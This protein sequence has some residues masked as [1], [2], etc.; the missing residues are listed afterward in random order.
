MTNHTR[1]QHHSNRAHHHRNHRGYTEPISLALI[2]HDRPSNCSSSIFYSYL[3]A[4]ISSFLVVLGIYLTLTRFEAHFLYISLVGLLI[5]ATS[6]CI[7]CLSNI[8]KSRLARRKQTDDFFLEN[9]QPIRH[10]NHRQQIRT[11]THILSN[12]TLTNQSPSAITNDNNTSRTIS[13][14]TAQ[15]NGIRD[16]TSVGVLTEHMVSNGHANSIELSRPDHDS[17]APQQARHLQFDHADLNQALLSNQQATNSLQQLPKNQNCYDLPNLSDVTQTIINTSQHDNNGN[18]DEAMTSAEP[19]YAYPSDPRVPI[20][21]LSSVGE[22]FQVPTAP[23]R[24][25]TITS[26]HDET[27]LID[28]QQQS[29][30]ASTSRQLEVTNDPQPVEGPMTRE[31]SAS[32]EPAGGRRRRRQQQR[33]ANFRRTLVMGLSGEEEVIEIDEEDLDNMSILPPSYESVATDSKH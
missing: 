14:S 19:P 7:Y 2:N 1:R 28:L 21:T 29:P 33:A 27:D 4:I 25:L 23:T 16:N 26:G 24:L 31:E 9:N 15:E 13:P 5:E 20:E 10:H 3:I 8:R 30:I 12:R 6:A 22:D 32:A 18:N 11:V 17:G